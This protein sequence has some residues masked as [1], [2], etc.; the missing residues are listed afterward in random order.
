MTELTKFNV[1]HKITSLDQDSIVAINKNYEAIVGTLKRYI[2][3]NENNKEELADSFATHDHDDAYSAL[4]HTHDV[5]KIGSQTLASASSVI[6]I[7]NISQDYRDLKLVIRAMSDD[8][9]GGELDDLY[10]NVNDSSDSHLHYLLKSETE[11]GSTAGVMTDN[12]AFLGLV[13]YIGFFSSNAFVTCTL[14]IFNYTSPDW[15]AFKSHMAFPY[16]SMEGTLIAIVTSEGFYL[17][18]DAVSRIDIYCL[19]GNLVGNSRVDI[20]GIK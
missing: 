10:F 4:G 16:E 3:L 19:E 9:L 20:Y 1:P 5:V 13:P 7:D 14:E 8:A 2:E 18:T 12:E 11:E 17:A 6:T 15:K